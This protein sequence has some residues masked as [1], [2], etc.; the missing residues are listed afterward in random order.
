MLE[1]RTAGG[2]K[3]AAQLAYGERQHRGK[4]VDFEPVVDRKIFIFILSFREHF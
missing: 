4:S 1:V 2:A 3:Q